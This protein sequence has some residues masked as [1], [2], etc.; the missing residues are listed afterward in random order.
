MSIVIGCDSFLSLR[1]VRNG[2][3]GRRLTERTGER[4][5][6]LVD[7]AQF[8][9]SVQACP[10]AITLDRLADFSPG[11]DR[12]LASLLQASTLTRKCY[13]DPRTIWSLLRASA[14][15]RSFFLRRWLAIA[16]ARWHYTR[17]RWDGWR[18][19]AQP[20]RR[21]F[22]EALRRHPVAAEYRRRFEA[23]D[24]RLVVAF[25]LEGNREMALVEAAN[26]AGIP[27]AVMIR[28]RDNLAAKIP[29]LPD[30]R[31]YLVWS[32]FTRD[33]LLRMYPEIP[34]ERVH[35]TGS[36]Q[37][38]RH[39]DPAFRL[40]RDEFFRRIGLDPQRPLV[41][42]TTATPRLIEHE[43][44]IVQHLADAVRDGRLRRSGVPAQL[45]VRGH[46][47]G[48]GSD[49]PLLKQLHPGVAVFPPPG[50]VPYRSA[51]HE[52]QV[53]RLILEDEPVH[54]ATLAYQ[55]VQVNVSGTMT[56]DSAIL[57]K[58]V[59]NIYYDLPA[60]V[61]AGLTVRRF[62]ERSDYQP[63]VASGGVRL[64]RSPEECL[65]LI[66]QY[67][68]NPALDAAGRKWIRETDCGPLDGR[69]GERIAERLAALCQVVSPAGAV[70]A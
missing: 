18:G 53:V 24:A 25:S 35:V 58:P 39:L 9:G 26:A 56:V 19:L 14:A 31:A 17:H 61:P 65:R 47:R 55:D 59:V 1:N 6:V 64:A 33:F 48:F 12:A 52:A 41:V 43:I 69:A 68:E 62:Y 36:P 28:S 70:P 45:L 15:R 11:T 16:K 5:I 3:L 37:F 49:H 60:D 44:H 22:A 21:A 30:A 8:D 27:A 34:P 23:W 20:R 51:E 10:A 50:S 38:D 46:P 29:H 66:N 57:D 7:P 13:Y 40:P 32:D 2:D 4:V 42:Y 54:L 67:L 63:I